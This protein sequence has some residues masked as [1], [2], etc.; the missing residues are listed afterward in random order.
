MT[1]MA[2]NVLQAHQAASELNAFGSS[3]ARLINNVLLNSNTK[4]WLFYR[5]WKRLVMSIEVVF[6]QLYV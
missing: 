5:S 4:H 3:A 1:V 2:Y 6:L